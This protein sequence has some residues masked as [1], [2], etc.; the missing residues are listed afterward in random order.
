MTERRRLLSRLFAARREE[1]NPAARAG[2]E[3]AGPRTAWL[4]VVQARLRPEAYR[5]PE[6]FSD[7]IVSLA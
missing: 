1:P 7:W 4:A 5:S 3:P 2:A 6:A